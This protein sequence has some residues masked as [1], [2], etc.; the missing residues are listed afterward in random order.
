M[1]PTLKRLL[2]AGA[3]T[4]A[5]GVVLALSAGPASAAVATETSASANWAGYVAQN[6]NFSA[7]SGRW[8]EPSAKCT[9]GGDGYSAFWVGLGGAS[10]ESNALE[11][12]GTQSDCSASGR[13]DYYAWYE[14]VPAAPV[15]LDLAVKPG[16]HMGGKVAVNGTTVTL[17][18]W[19]YT[20]GQSATK[21]VQ[22]SNIDTSSAE[23]IAEAPSECDGT[24]NCQPMPLADFGTV[25][26]TNATATAGGH[27]GPI[28]DPSW[29]AQAVDLDGSSGSHFGALGVAY[30]QSGDTGAAQTSTLTNSGAAFSVS[31]ASALGADSSSSSST[32]SS[33]SGDGGYGSGGGGYG[34]GGGGY[35]Y[36]Y[37]DGGSGYGGYGG[38]YGYGGGDGGW[39]Y[40]F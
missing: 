32:A 21:T 23:W 26:F 7:V 18:I 20:T 33:G 16:D 27:S 28:S 24:G 4:V 15:K 17:T 2:P 35:P 30:Q 31:W 9:S 13:T 39:A 3:A 25:K 8:T 5:T 1:K 36:G 6:N 34:D 14:L 40:A 29:Q 11:Q 10:G 19:D 38:G 22:T 12:V 37:G